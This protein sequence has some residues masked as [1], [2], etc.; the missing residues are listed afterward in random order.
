[1][2]CV[3]LENRTRLAIDVELESVA[4]VL[5]VFHSFIVDCLNKPAQGQGVLP[6][7]TLVTCTLNMSN[8]I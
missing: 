1:M 4:F 8:L 5:K 3:K 2:R 6:Q 7:L